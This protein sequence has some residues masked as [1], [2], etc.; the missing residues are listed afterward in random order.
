MANEIMDNQLKLVLGT[1][2][3]GPQ[4]D[5]QAARMM[6]DS[7]VSRGFN[8][9]DAAYVYNE[10]LTETMIGQL[11]PEFS[12]QKISIATKANPRISGKLD[13]RAVVDQ[14][15]ESLN[16]M[17]LTKVDLL[18]LHMP[19]GNTPVQSALE[20]YAELFN[21][22]MVGGFGLSNFPAWMVADIYHLCTKLSVPPPIVYQ[23]LYNGVSRNVEQELFD[24]LRSFKM[25]FYAFNPLAGGLLSG[26]QLNFDAE[27]ESGRFQRLA[28]YRQRYWKRDFFEAIQMLVSVAKEHEILPAEAA[29]RWLVHH[30]FLKKDHGDAIILGAS[31]INQLLSN[32]KA[33]DAVALPEDL[34]EAFQMAWQITKSDSPP[35]F[36]FF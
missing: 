13:K 20:G 11:L 26:K 35:Y 6:I 18:Y 15:Q 17:Q 1:M 9:L 7:C 25:S 5:L 4:V 14:C 24:C 29:Y 32:L 33:A 36:S 30:S 31:S 10:G 16:R 28:S 34:V 23:G 27:P 19:D 21:K 12:D 3:F 22:G 2:N 8:E